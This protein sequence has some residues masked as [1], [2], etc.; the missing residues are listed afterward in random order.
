MLK[1][2]IR[3]LSG[4]IRRKA[5]SPVEV[6]KL[7]IERAL[8]LNKK[9]NAFINLVPEKAI[10]QAK[11]IEKRILGGYDAGVLLGIPIAF[12]DNINTKG[13]ATSNG[14]V[15]DWNHVPQEDAL[16]VQNIYKAGAINIG[17]TNL[18]EYAFGITSDNPH[19]GAVLNPWH[20][21]YS[22]GGS[23]GGS[24]VAVATLMCLGAMGTDTGGSIRVPASACGVVGLKPTFGIIDRT[25]IC[26]ISRTLDHVGPIAGTVDDLS[27][28]MDALLGHETSIFEKQLD[29]GI[30]GLRIGVPANYFND[31]IDAG[32]SRLV[33]KAVSE[34]ASLGATLVEINFPVMDEVL[35]TKFIISHAEVS[36]VHQDR[37][38]TNLDRYGIAFRDVLKF[39]ESISANYYINALKERERLDGEVEDLFNRVDAIVTPT[40]PVPPQKIGVKDVVINGKAESIFHCITRYTSPF[41]LTG[42]PA[43][44]MPVGV[45]DG[46][47]VG[48]QIVSAKRREELLFRLGYA[49]EKVALEGFYNARSIKCDTSV[50]SG[51]VAKSGNNYNDFFQE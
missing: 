23:S 29:R 19:F 1:L 45:M 40:L 4:A 46:L 17:K 20:L 43:L 22:P 18:D 3:E 48:L 50:F 8:E 10:D 25:G 15:V 32:V 33:N 47:P 21:E 16:V 49:Y 11:D 35:E 42:Q 31:N 51:I 37:M 27:F 39:G 2:S 5:I 30:K 28:M 24:A 14:S 7:F 6:I 9:Y 41:S 13:I 38:E 34:L 12:K 36:F 44:S 26:P